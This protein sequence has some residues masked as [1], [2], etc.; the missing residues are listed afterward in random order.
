M[1][2]KISYLYRDADNYK[3]HNECVVEGVFSEAQKSMM[4]NS[5]DEGEYFIPHKVGLPE[6]RFDKFDP[7]VDHI[8]FELGEN[9][10]SE[11]SEN[12][13]VSMSA[14]E[15]V[16][17][18]CLCKDRW[19]T[20]ARE[21]ALSHINCSARH[22]QERE[23][24]VPEW[25]IPVSWEMSGFVKVKAPSLRDAMNKVLTD[26]SI[27]L[28]EGSYVDASFDLS[29][30]DEDAI[31]TCYNNNRPD[32]STFVLCLAATKES[33]LNSTPEET[34]ELNSLED[35]IAECSVLREKSRAAGR[36]DYYAAYVVAEDGSNPW[37]EIFDPNEPQKMA[38]E[39]L[40]THPS[41]DTAI[42]QAKTQQ[43]LSR[44]CSTT[45]TPPEQTH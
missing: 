1:N 15:L 32:Q 35:C 13:S 30:D 17:A 29:M 44:N 28:P 22:H 14:E 39:E 2:T 11:T 31:R 45:R 38:T 26:E 34:W 4:I 24:F 8:W 10:F 25:T 41:L 23:N 33:F 20:I 27:P 9:S 19:E 5:L 36:P 43:H 6:K 12:P 3:V 21:E 16:E 7:Q 18:F 42:Q 40:K 37:K